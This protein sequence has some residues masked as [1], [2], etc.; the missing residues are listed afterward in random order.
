MAAGLF[1]PA[2]AFGFK[3]IT[4]SAFGKIMEGGSGAE[5]EAHAD[6]KEDDDTQQSIRFIISMAPLDRLILEDLDK[7]YNLLQDFTRPEN[8]EA[9]LQ[10]LFCNWDWTY[11]VSSN[12]INL[13]T[14]PVGWSGLQRHQYLQHALHLAGSFQGYAVQEFRAR[15]AQDD[16]E[17][18]LQQLGKK[19]VSCIEFVPSSNDDTHWDILSAMFLRHPTEMLFWMNAAARRRLCRRRNKSLEW[20]VG[21]FSIHTVAHIFDLR[22]RRPANVTQMQNIF[23]SSI[24]AGDM[25]VSLRYVGAP[26][27]ELLR[28][29]GP[30]PGA[31]RAQEVGDVLSENSDIDSATSNPQQIIQDQEHRSTA[32]SAPVSEESVS[33]QPREW[34]IEEEEGNTVQVRD[35]EEAAEARI[36]AAIAVREMPSLT[37]PS[38]ATDACRE[39]L[40]PW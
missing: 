35:S 11:T 19:P 27:F 36:M 9:L 32:L 31:G 4:P 29:Q 30:H 5:E 12:I 20:F 13:F 39:H 21:H 28:Y 18:F 3:T 40:G 24:N 17:D 23:S 38:V 2:P 10:H 33:S 22:C 26:G 1:V 37:L 15:I 25:L 16:N 6:V 34:E 14:N 7:R 8:H